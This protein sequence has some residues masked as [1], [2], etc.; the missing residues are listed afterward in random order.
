MQLRMLPIS[1]SSCYPAMPAPAA[2]PATVAAANRTEAAAAAAA[3]AATDTEAVP[4]LAHN[5]LTMRGVV[6]PSSFVSVALYTLHCKPYTSIPS[7]A[8]A[9]VKP[10][11]AYTHLFDND[12]RCGAVLV[13]KRGLV[14]TAKAAR[15]QPLAQ[16]QVVLRL[17][18]DS[19]FILFWCYVT[20]C[21]SDSKTQEHI[22]ATNVAHA[23]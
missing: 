6:V 10:G 2:G 14:H 19:F 1:A 16:L 4:M 7:A 15:A 22:V 11:D 8:A 9:A 23:R 3:A 20:L 18:Y 21:N 17:N 12:R 13:C 5:F